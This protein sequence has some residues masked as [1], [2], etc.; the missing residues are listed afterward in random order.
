MTEHQRRSQQPEASFGDELSRIGPKVID[1][2]YLATPGESSSPRFSAE[3]F[4]ASYLDF[5]QWTGPTSAGPFAPWI[6]R[7]VDLTKAVAMRG[8]LIGAVTTD[9]QQCSVAVGVGGNKRWSIDAETTWAGILHPTRAHSTL[10]VGS[11]RGS[12]GVTLRLQGPTTSFH[13]FKSFGREPLWHLGVPVAAELEQ[14]AGTRK[15]RLRERWRQRVEF[16]NT[17][18]RRLWGPKSQR[19]DEAKIPFVRIGVGLTVRR[20]PIP[21][22]MPFGGIAAELTNRTSVSFHT[23]V[24]HRTC[25]TLTSLLTERLTMAL[26]LRCNLITF[27]DT[28]LDA[29]FEYRVPLSATADTKKAAGSGRATARSVGAVDDSPT[30]MSIRGSVVYDRLALGVSTED[31]LTAAS[32]LIR[33]FNSPN[34]SK[35]ADSVGTAARDIGPIRLTCG[36]EVL[37]PIS[38]ADAPITSRGLWTWNTLAP[39]LVLSIAL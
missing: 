6:A 15:G 33:L 35:I 14:S 20:G 28:T 24:L 18:Q 3:S 38:E 9:V 26:R 2:A 8:G 7:F 36:V 31:A 34:S 4:R 11:P 12:L 16:S 32:R 22:A 37:V 29:G 25:G 23:D 17:L 21:G 13:V 30:A 27:A 10:H 1:W 5:G 19:L 39:R